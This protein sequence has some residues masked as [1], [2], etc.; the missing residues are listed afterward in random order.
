[1]KRNFVT[2]VLIGLGLFSGTV[3]AQ[4]IH[5][6]VK[7]G[8]D[9][10]KLTGKS[11]SDQFS[12]GYHLGGQLEIGLGKVIGI[13]P[14]VYFSQVNIDTTDKFS[15]VYQFNK[16]SSVKL[17]YLNIPILLSIKPNKYV[18]L[19]V[20]PQYGI[21]MNK[22][23]TLLQNGKQAFK[24]GD[25][26]MLAGIQLNISKVRLYGRYGVGLS[27]LNDIDNQDKWKSQTIH[28]GLGLTF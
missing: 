20:G 10:K 24:N 22:D 23:N 8:T 7:V 17:Q 19:L 2:I 4:G 9:I 14:E 16:I 5:L 6:G 18:A 27:A 12:Y 25:F 21:L 28:L 3:F 13:Q 11:F 15:Q 1:M 26:S